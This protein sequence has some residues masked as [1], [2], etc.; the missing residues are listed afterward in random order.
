MIPEI[1]EKMLIRELK[2]L[3]IHKVVNRKA[4]PEISSKVEYSLSKFLEKNNTITQVNKI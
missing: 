4:Y 1:S 3:K 2:S